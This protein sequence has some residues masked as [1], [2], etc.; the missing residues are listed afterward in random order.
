MR[1]KSKDGAASCW[2]HKVLKFA[3]PQVLPVKNNHNLSIALWVVSCR[4]EPSLLTSFLV[5]CSLCSL[6]Q[7]FPFGLALEYLQFVNAL[8]WE[9]SV[10][11]LS[12][13]WWIIT[14]SVQNHNIN[15]FFIIWVV[16]LEEWNIDQLM[17]GNV[18]IQPIAGLLNQRLP[19]A[20]R[21][22]EA[23]CVMLNIYG[24]WGVPKK[25][26]VKSTDVLSSVSQLHG[27]NTIVGKLFQFFY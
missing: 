27:C 3:L 12:Q 1:Q 8:C 14:C 11:N 20:L 22:C 18:S 5:H 2:T 16:S 21:I 23:A 6:K 19:V 15:V 9:F 4:Y 13:V 24:S 10:F 26:V 25:L 7:S 17:W